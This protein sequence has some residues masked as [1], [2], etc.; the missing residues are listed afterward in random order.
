MRILYVNDA[1]AIWGGLER[2][3]IEKMNYLADSFGFEIFTLTYNQ[4]DHPVPYPI[5]KQVIFRDL[6]IKLFSQYRYRGLKRL[7][8]KYKL[9][10]LLLSRLKTGIQEIKPDVIVTPRIDLLGVLLKSSVKIPIVYESHSSCKWITFDNDGLLWRLK[11]YYYKTLAS[12]SDMVVALTKSD[13]MEWR[14]ITSKVCVIPNIVNLN[15]TGRYSDCSSKSAIFVGRLSKQK[16]LEGLLQIWSIAYQHF[17]MWEL[18]IYGET[19]DDGVKQMLLKSVEEM[20]ANIFI[21][22]PTS[23]IIEK[24]IE[25]SMLLLTSFYEPFGLVLPEAMSCGIPVVAFDCPYGPVD[26]ITDGVD[27][28]LIPERNIEIFSNRVCELMGSRDKRLQMG[29][30]GIASSKRYDASLV[31]PQWKQLFND[32]LCK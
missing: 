31:M 22:E 5:S 21:H 8:Y 3:V 25:S 29:K 23:K 17:P 2:V 6:N 30:S 15:N 10:S 11:R 7:Y 14:K 27:G 28:F 13:A 24:Y 9:Q 1:W 18:H 16:D 19:G 4:G 20:N 32:L 26:I 12:K